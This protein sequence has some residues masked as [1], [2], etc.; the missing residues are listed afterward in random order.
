MDNENVS[1]VSAVFI[2]SKTAEMCG[3]IKISAEQKKCVIHHF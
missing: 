3:K 2:L 1:F